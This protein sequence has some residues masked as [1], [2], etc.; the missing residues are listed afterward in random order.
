MVRL[1]IVLLVGS[2]SHRCLAQQ[3][4]A[5]VWK[6]G[7]NLANTLDFG[8]IPVT[9]TKSIATFNLGVASICDSNGIYQFSAGSFGIVNRKDT[10]MPKGQTQPKYGY[11]GYGC[12]L[13]IPFQNDNRKYHYF[14]ISNR[15]GPLTTSPPY[16]IYHFTIDMTLDGG[17]GDMDTTK[18]EII[19]SLVALQIACM[20]HANGQDSWLIAR[21]YQSDS[22]IA[23]LITDSGA[24]Q[25]VVTDISSPVKKPNL[26]YESVI[27]SQ[28]DS[29]L[30]SSPDSKLLLIPRRMK[31]YPYSE[32][33]QFDRETGKFTNRIVIT[34]TTGDFYITNYGDGCFSPNSKKLYYTIGTKTQTGTFTEGPG[35]FW[36]YDI[37]T[38]DSAAIVQSKIFLGRLGRRLPNVAEA[39]PW[40]PKMQ[41]A[42]DGKIYISPGIRTD[43]YMSTIRCPDKTGADCG[44]EFRTIDLGDGKN[45]AYFPTLNQTF[46]R[47]AGIFQVQANKRKL[48]Q[49]DTLEMSGYGA[50]AE[51]FKWSVSPA[52]PVSVKVDT[53]TW[54]KIPTQTIPPGSYTFTCQAFSR[55]G[56]VFEKSMVVTIN[57]NPS[58]SQP[59]QRGGVNTPC[60]GDSVFVFVA[61]PKAGYRY[62]WNTGQI[63]DTIVVK[64]SGKYALDSVANGFGCGIKTA[65][66]VVVVIKDAIIPPIPVMASPPLVEICQGASAQ[67]SILHSQFSIQ[68]KWSN[69]QEG[70]SVLVG[71]GQY[72]V[73]SISDSGCQSAPSQVVTVVEGSNPKPVLVNIDTNLTRETLE[74]QNYCVAG[75]PGSR[76]SFSVQNGTIVDSSE[77]CITVNWAVPQLSIIHYQLSIKETLQSPTCSGTASQTLS[78]RP[79]LQ[80]PTLITP[81]NDSKNDAFEIH[82]LSFYPNHRLQIFNRWGMKVLE[83]SQYRNDWKGDAGIYFYQLTIDGKDNKG[84][85]QVAK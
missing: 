34:D 39:R 2:L 46:V 44:L 71:G 9:R 56:D 60:V 67:L 40:A 7:E 58:P 63:A 16:F 74:N 12:N 49:G 28:F 32:L 84:W 11:S 10:L 15:G 83:T 81:N 8:T 29:Q 6:Y 4:Q 82:D 24:V 61:N 79:K 3:R 75:Q 18:T 25:K 69:G 85:V 76:F 78:Y 36:Q 21:G 52:L 62:F 50:G 33:L 19:D 57:A 68:H 23:Y 73:V 54:Q 45:G 20:L 1:L 80:I 13:I 30:K 31:E 5:Q 35:H 59:P 70:D 37:S 51:H 77:D 22:L 55:C 72:S 41:L 42:M 17:K 65:D 66:T 43:K 53:L 38:Y 64:Q 14:M 48:C 47:N 26:G 27:G